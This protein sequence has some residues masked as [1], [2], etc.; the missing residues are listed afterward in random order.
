MDGANLYENFA[1]ATT[2]KGHVP[3]ESGVNFTTDAMNMEREAWDEEKMEKERKKR[4]G[5]VD[6]IKR[7]GGR[8]TA[9]A[10]PESVREGK[11]GE[12]DLEEVIKDDGADEGG[13]EGIKKKDGRASEFHLIKGLLL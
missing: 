8:G 6:K 4:L 3:A 12:E 7:E 5:G 10:P 13:E 1:E 11:E 9:S 2:G